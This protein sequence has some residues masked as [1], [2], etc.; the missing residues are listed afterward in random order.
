MPF[1]AV[2]I[3]GADQAS[4][5]TEPGLVLAFPQ[6][7][8]DTTAWA[9]AHAARSWQVKT[10]PSVLEMSDVRVTI[11]PIDLVRVLCRH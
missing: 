11:G 8:K 7:L 5:L 9:H 6:S 10:S 2:N 1:P 3:S 4:I